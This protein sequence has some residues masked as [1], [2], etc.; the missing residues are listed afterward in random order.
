MTNP[1]SFYDQVTRL[2]DE[3]NAVDVVY[4]DLSKD[5]DSVSH[6]IL[7]EKLEGHGLE[8]NTLCRVK[9]WM[10][11][12]TQRVVVNGITSSL[13]PVTSDVPWLW[14]AGGWPLFPGNQDLKKK[15]IIYLGLGKSVLSYSMIVSVISSCTNKE[16][17]L[18]FN[19]PGQFSR[20]DQQ[21]PFHP[22]R[23]TYSVFLRFI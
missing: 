19:I 4:L 5:F 9:N 8:R 2:V 22:I 12:Q 14:R 16:R 20:T 18:R 3:G 10:E 1:I 7:L 6:S 23:I 17:N 15:K 21:I 13:Q 11:G